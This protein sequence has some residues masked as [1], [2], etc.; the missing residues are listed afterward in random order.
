MLRGG[1]H[2]TICEEQVS[3]PVDFLQ[4]PRVRIYLLRY[5]HGVAAAEAGV[6]IC[7]SISGILQTEQ[8]RRREPG[9][10]EEK[11]LE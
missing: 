3:T 2:Q 4:D 1:T 11:K 6:A 10:P 8:A 9:V 5:P 7:V